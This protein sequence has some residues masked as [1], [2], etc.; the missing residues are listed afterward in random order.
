MQLRT[1]SPRSRSTA[2]MMVAPD[3]SSFASSVTSLPCSCRSLASKR[4]IRS[5]NW[6]GV[7]VCVFQVYGVLRTKC[8]F[9]VNCLRVKSILL[10]RT[11]FILSG[12]GLPYQC[13]SGYGTCR[14]APRYSAAL[15]QLCTN[16]ALDGRLKLLRIELA[17]NAA[18][19]GLKSVQ[20][21]IAR[22]N[23]YL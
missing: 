2:M 12:M 19:Q 18:K 9:K 21:D 23:T 11:R 13:G 15:F 5:R 6:G 10:P 4:G 7:F 20:A 14:C 3:S 16:Q 8:N 17:D 22:Y 1:R